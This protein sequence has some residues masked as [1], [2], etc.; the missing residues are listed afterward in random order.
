MTPLKTKVEAAAL[1]K[2]SPRTLQG[3]MAKRKI[4]YIRVGGRVRFSDDDLE[5][6]VI[7]HRVRLKMI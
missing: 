6:F 5:A 3:F 4:R 7:A 1:L 2:I